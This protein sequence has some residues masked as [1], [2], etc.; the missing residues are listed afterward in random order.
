[1]GGTRTGFLFTVPDYPSAVALRVS[2]A[3]FPDP[4]G[5]EGPGGHG[6]LEFERRGVLRI[7][8]PGLM[9]PIQLAID[10]AGPI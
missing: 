6:R 5:D 3:E 7:F 4:P 1:V 9:A 10:D 2:G 8:R